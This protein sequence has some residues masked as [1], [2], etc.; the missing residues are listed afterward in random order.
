MNKK[1]EER[2]NKNGTKMNQRGPKFHTITHPPG[3]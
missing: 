2:K 1:Q 3:H